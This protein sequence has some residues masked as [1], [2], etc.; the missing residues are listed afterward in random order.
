MKSLYL[1]IWCN[2]L[3]SQVFSQPAD[4]DCSSVEDYGINQQD[5]LMG[6]EY[7]NPVRGYTGEQY[8]N[9]WTPGEVSLYNG[10]VIKNILLRYERYLDELL[11][12]RKTDF[13]TGILQKTAILGFRLV[14]EQ[15]RPTADFIKKKILLPMSDS[16]EAYLQVLASGQVAF[17]AYRNVNVTTV[18]YKLSNNTRYFICTGGNDF[19]LTLKR[20][21]LLNLP[22][23]QKAEMKSIL[24]VNRISVSGNEQEFI[25]AIELYNNRH[26]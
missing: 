10:E 25:R 24:R 9:D 18:E 23:V 17:Y 11:W 3:I 26:K 8:F 2:L 15:D 16:T 19:L 7:S 5:G 4:C 20:K 22:V 6:I 1:F 13:A 12:L 21:S 14:D